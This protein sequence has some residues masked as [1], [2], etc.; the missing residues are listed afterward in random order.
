MAT[1]ANDSATEIRDQVMRIRESA[2]LESGQGPDSA[3]SS[4]RE[5]A[6]A[7]RKLRHI[8][9]PR[10]LGYL[11]IDYLTIA[12]IFVAGWFFLEYRQQ[13]GWPWWVTLAFFGLGAI[14]MGGVQ[15]RLAAIAHEASHYTLL[16]NRVLNDL[17]GDWLCLFP[18]MS[19]VQLYRL[20]HMGHH[21]F[22]NDPTFDPDFRNMERYWDGRLPKGRWG[23]L[24]DTYLR[25]LL[26]PMSVL[27]YGTDYVLN[28][29][30]AAV[31]SFY[32]RKIG[33]VPPASTRMRPGPILAVVWLILTDIGM[34]AAERA[35]RLD[36]VLAAAGFGALVAVAG[37]FTLPDRW[38]YVSP[39]REPYPVRVASA[40]R[41][42]FLIGGLLTLNTMRAWTGGRSTALFFGLWV[43]PLLTTFMYYMLL[44]EIYQHGNT[45]KDRIT[46]TRVFR[47]DPFTRWA[48]FVHGQDLHTPHHMYP[49]IPHYALEEAHE[50]LKR[51]SGDYRDRVI[52]VE[53]TL[54][55]GSSQ[56]PTIQDVVSV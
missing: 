9:G 20:N 28:N 10:N 23:F 31:D 6:D 29:V 4:E 38:M 12:V 48:V 26:S 32:L 17:V 25:P 50:T 47:V 40:M 24:A 52:E 5:L 36:L 55:H 45:D 14:V 49:A 54:F 8:D 18:L 46:N 19:S 13:Y 43:F 41:L 37:A 15:H 22:V 53:G 44:R 11:A 3:K 2:R 16:K 34:I 1:A 39:F 51:F 56:L 30:F 7:L 21:Q 27:R 33:I 42:V 35:G